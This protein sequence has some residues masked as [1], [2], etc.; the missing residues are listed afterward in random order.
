MSELYEVPAII[1]SAGYTIQ[2]SRWVIKHLGNFVFTR[3]VGALNLV[4]VKNLKVKPLS[5]NPNESV[6]FLLGVEVVRVCLGLIPSLF[7]QLRSKDAKDL[8]I[9]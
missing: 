3:V 1:V 2:L 9:S 7:Y 6:P 5:H 4:P 8:I